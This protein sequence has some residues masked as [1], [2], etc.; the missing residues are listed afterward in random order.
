MCVWVQERD[1]KEGILLEREPLCLFNRRRS[2]LVVP[3]E[4]GRRREEGVGGREDVN[5]EPPE[6]TQTKKY[7]KKQNGQVFKWAMAGTIADNQHRNQP[8]TCTELRGC[9]VHAG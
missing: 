7:L 6:D 4:G 8:N 9:V 3:K 2:V 1:A 5:T